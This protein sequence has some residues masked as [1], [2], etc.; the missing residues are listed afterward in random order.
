MDSCRPDYQ[1]PLVLSLVGEML[2]EE[3]NRSTQESNILATSELEGSSEV[4]MKW[5][6]VYS[7]PF[8]YLFPFLLNEL[9]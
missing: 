9:S 3:E 4:V 2:G 7:T 8:I 1:P 6:Y 5:C